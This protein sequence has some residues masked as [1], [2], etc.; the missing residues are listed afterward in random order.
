MSH[1]VLII[2]EG[3]D[4]VRADIGL[5]QIMGI[6]RAHIVQLITEGNVIIDNAPI[7]K[8]ARL[9]S[10][11]LVEIVFPEVTRNEV[12]EEHSIEGM[13]VIYLDDDIVVVDKPAGVAA[14]PSLGWTGPTVLGGLKALGISV[15][16]HGPTERRGIVHRL[17]AGTSGVMVL[18]RSN[19]S[20]SAL[21]YAFK[22][23]TV[24]KEYHA[25]VHGHPDPFAGTIDTPIMKTKGNEWKFT[26][27]AAGKHAVTHYST[28]E[29]FPGATLL[30]IHLETGRTHQIRVH[31]SAMG[32]PCVGDVLYGADR[33]VAAK[34]QLDRQWL[35]AKKIGFIHP[36]TNEYVTYESEYP[37][38]LADALTSL[39]Y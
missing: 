28:L 4:G 16:T 20:Y 30:H 29:A 8:S 38:V 18:A 34:L 3:L 1:K 2:P 32:H 33:T 21:K 14:H 6:S 7:L 19:Q 25:L 12:I 35:H 17:D 37:Q 15:S 5:S 22:H 36:Y 24:D 10:G 27:H 11:A 23:R 9:S 13:K 26:I 31:F 39:R